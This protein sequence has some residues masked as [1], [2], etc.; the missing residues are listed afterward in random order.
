MVV[1]PRHH[2]WVERG[3]VSLAE[4]TEASLI[5]REVGSG[6]RKVIEQF[7]K[8]QGMALSD[9]KVAMELGSMQSIKKVVAAGLG[10]TI[11][12]NLTIQ[13]R[14][15]LKAVKIQDMDMKRELSIVTNSANDSFTKEELYFIKV[16]RNRHLLAKVLGHQGT[17]NEDPGE[18]ESSGVGSAEIKLIGNGLTENE[19]AKNKFIENGTIE[20]KLNEDGVAK[21]GLTENTP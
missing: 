9:F 6:T 5:L 15:S 10:V 20:N 2:P 21:N 3:S 11:I 8:Q 16:L 4:L 14:H 17:D 7:L 19:P 18:S 13:K 1:V 12:S